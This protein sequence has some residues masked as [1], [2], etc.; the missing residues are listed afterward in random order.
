MKLR[1]RG[2][3]NKNQ[4]D[5]ICNIPVRPKKKGVGG[6]NIFWFPRA[7]QLPHL[8]HPPPPHISQFPLFSLWPVTLILAPLLFFF[9]NQHNTHTHTPLPHPPPVH[10]L[11]PPLPFFWQNHWKILK[12]ITPSHKLFEVKVLISLNKKKPKEI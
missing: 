4:K 7:F 3:P 2:N 12:N 1:Q 11:S 10:S 6:A 9:F 5:Y 8:T